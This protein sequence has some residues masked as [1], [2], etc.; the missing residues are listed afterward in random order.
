MNA[1]MIM[2]TPEM[3]EDILPL[4][5]K[6]VDEVVAVQAKH[7]LDDVTAM[8]VLVAAGA[9]YTGHLGDSFCACDACEEVTD[10]IAAQIGGRLLAKQ[11][12]R[13]GMN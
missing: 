10:A 12:S 2:I 9:M 6:M 4:V 8:A 7:K 3:W 5:A 11:V 13:R 1:K